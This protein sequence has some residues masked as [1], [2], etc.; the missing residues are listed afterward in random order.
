MWRRRAL[1]GRVRWGAGRARAVR[2]VR[3]RVDGRQPRGDRDRPGGTVAAA[4]G[5]GAAS[6]GASP[7]GAA[8]RAGGAARRAGC[9]ADRREWAL[10]AGG[11]AAWAGRW[12]E[13]A[14]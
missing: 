4:G 13:G 8:G 1:P 9:L 5:G 14:G 6:V 2:L 11:G 7:A 12:L 10:A 3:A